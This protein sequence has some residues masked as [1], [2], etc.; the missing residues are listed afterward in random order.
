MGSI[1]ACCQKTCGVTQ[2]N[3]NSPMSAGKKRAIVISLIAVTLLLGGVA[4]ILGTGGFHHFGHVAREAFTSSTQA[5]V[6]V[7]AG[8]GALLVGGAIGGVLGSRRSN[9]QVKIEFQ[10][11]QNDKSG[12]G[13]EGDDQIN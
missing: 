13:G 8:G 3:Q 6:A 2:K 10:P 1:K 5:W 12:E 11:L 9:A 4:A 7:A